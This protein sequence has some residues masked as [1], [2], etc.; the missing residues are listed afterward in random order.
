MFYSV[1]SI[2]HLLNNLD[3]KLLDIN[4]NL[5]K[6]YIDD[7]TEKSKCSIPMKEK[8]NSKIKTRCNGNLELFFGQGN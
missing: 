2:I 3:L 5:E 7:V 6:R 1:D 8:E 4:Y